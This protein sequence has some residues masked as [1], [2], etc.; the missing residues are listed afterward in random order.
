VQ[1]DGFETSLYFARH[2]DRPKMSSRKH[3]YA[4]SSDCEHVAL[5]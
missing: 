2:R 1:C 3:A 5:P 4:V